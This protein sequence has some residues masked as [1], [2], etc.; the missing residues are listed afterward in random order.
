MKFLKNLFQTDP[1]KETER[2]I[3][4]IAL[5]SAHQLEVLNDTSYHHPQVIFKHSTSCGISGMV[6][7]SFQTQSDL[8]DQGLSYYLLDLIRYRDISNAI[9]EKYGVRH[10]SPQVLVIRDGEVVAHASHHDVTAIDLNEW[11]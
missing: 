9:A 11:T 6:K 5:H 8:P 4:W 1:V 7:R 2:G 3:N 10:E